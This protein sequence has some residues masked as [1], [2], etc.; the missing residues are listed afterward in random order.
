MPPTSELMGRMAHRRAVEALIWGMPAVNADLMFQAMARAVRGDWNQVVY[1]S[2]LVD[3]KNQTLTPNPDAIYIMPFFNT[4]QTGPMVLEIPAAGEGSITGSIMDSGKRRSRM[5][6]RPVSTRGG[7]QISHPASR[8]F[9]PRT[10]RSHPPSVTDL[11]GLRL[12]ALDSDERQRCRFWQSARLWKAHPSLSAVRPREPADDDLSRRRRGAFRRDHPLR[13][14]LLRVTRAH[15]G[16]P[17]WFPV[18]CLLHMSHLALKA[19][20]L[21]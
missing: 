11:S 12:V 13:C 20:G 17:I 9:R 1:W 14:A 8:S 3:W 6:G 18:S 5:S 2:R 21:R 7:R 4:A 10:G 15:R 19:I 16:K